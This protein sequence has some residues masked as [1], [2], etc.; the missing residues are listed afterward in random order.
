MKH[1]VIPTHHFTRKWE[2]T[3]LDAKQ[4]CTS[5]D[6]HHGCGFI[7]R[8]SMT[9]ASFEQLPSHEDVNALSYWR[10]D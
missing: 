10:R 7:Y 2:C 1:V 6:P 4:D 5:W 9:E 3:K 8:I